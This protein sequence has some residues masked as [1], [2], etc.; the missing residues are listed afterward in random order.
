MQV[1]R[2]RRLGVRFD[3]RFG[4]GARLATGEEFIFLTDVLGRGGEIDFVPIELASHA[5]ESS[6][7]RR[8]DA[9]VLTAKGAMF[10]RTYGTLGAL[11]AVAFVLRKALQGELDVGPVSGIMSALEGWRELRR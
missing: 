11:A 3:E 9:A 5:A 10:A 7:R 6:G 8:L 1:A 4:P 2:I